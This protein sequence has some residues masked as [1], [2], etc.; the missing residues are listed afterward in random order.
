[1]ANSNDSKQVF[2]LTE[3]GERTYW[4]RIGAAFTNKDG[5]ISVTLDALPV[6]G[7][8]QIRDQEDRDERQGRGAEESPHM[9]PRT[10]RQ[11]S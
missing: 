9:T 10:S 7:R 5:S 2:A 1:M 4:T 3:R 8:L 11:I 6:S